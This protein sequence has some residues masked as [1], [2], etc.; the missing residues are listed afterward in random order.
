MC[1][2]L[3]SASCFRV[4]VCVDEAESSYSTTMLHPN[5][6]VRDAKW[7]LSKN[8]HLGYVFVHV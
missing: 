4:C 8:M 7:K 2:S 5:Q 3:V 6:E 1:L